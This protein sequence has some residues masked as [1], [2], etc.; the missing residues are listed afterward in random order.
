MVADAT[1]GGSQAT[2]NGAKGG[3]RPRP[4]QSAG[5]GSQPTPGLIQS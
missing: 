5:A 4:P 1:L 3:G 2:P